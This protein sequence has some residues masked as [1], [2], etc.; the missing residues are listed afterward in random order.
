MSGYSM[1]FMGAAVMALAWIFVRYHGLDW[2]RVLVWCA[3]SFLFILG[4]M[5]TMAAWHDAVFVV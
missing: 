2:P 5:K 4:M 3:G 1:M